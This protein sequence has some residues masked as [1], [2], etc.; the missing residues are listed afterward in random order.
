MSGII[1]DL[2]IVKNN[3][4]CFFFNLCRKFRIYVPFN[5]AHISACYD[6]MMEKIFQVLL[7]SKYI[8]SNIL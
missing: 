1:C 4:G 6:A 8:F 3:T 2:C 5:K 7:V